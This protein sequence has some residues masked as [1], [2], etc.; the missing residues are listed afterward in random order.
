M[1]PRACI[2]NL[3][4]VLTKPTCF[5]AKPCRLKKGAIPFSRATLGS[6]R[7]RGHAFPGWRD[8]TRALVPENAQSLSKG[9]GPVGG[10]LVLNREKEVKLRLWYVV[11]KAGS[12][13]LMDGN[14]NEKMSSN[15]DKI[16]D[17]VSLAFVV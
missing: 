15:Y 13:E 7:K 1:T 12:E 6:S 16:S 11:F 5:C 8:A 3:V 10:E 2:H 4:P 17:R 9:G 14:G